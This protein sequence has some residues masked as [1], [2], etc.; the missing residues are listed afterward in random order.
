MTGLVLLARIVAYDMDDQQVGIT[1]QISV[2]LC[3]SPGHGLISHGRP[4]VIVF[5]GLLAKFR[6]TVWAVWA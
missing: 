6:P 1:R 5:E 3:D 4:D 2:A